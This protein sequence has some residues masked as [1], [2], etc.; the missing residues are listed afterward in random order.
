[1][2]DGETQALN[3]VEIYGSCS[4]DHTIDFITRMIHQARIQHLNPTN[5]DPASQPGPIKLD[6]DRQW[7]AWKLITKYYEALLEVHYSPIETSRQSK[8][9]AIVILWESQEK[10]RYQKKKE[11]VCR[12]SEMLALFLTRLGSVGDSPQVVQ[13]QRAYSPVANRDHRLR[14]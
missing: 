2:L 13:L 5:G 1:M 8:A 14:S 10:V 3:R 9:Q 7:S 11:W 12:V 4:W 6:P